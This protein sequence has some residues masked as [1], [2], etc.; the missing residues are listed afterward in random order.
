ME[1]KGSGKGNIAKPIGLGVKQTK[2]DGKAVTFIDKLYQVEEKLWRDKLDTLLEKIQSQGIILAKTR[3]LKGLKKYKSLVKSFMKEAIN[4]S[5][6]LKQNTSW[7]QWGKHRMLTIV[8]KVDEN[9]EELARLMME[10]EEKTLAIL[11]KLDEIK[12]L[13]VDLYT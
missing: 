12:G 2:S 11:D 3:D 5:L 8:E 13:L 10:G 4:S 9:I 1:I 7:N 6:K